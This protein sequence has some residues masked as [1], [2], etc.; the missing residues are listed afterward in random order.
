MAP[1]WF[2][3]HPP[4]GLK[5]RRAAGMAGLA[6]M[7]AVL[8]WFLV[9]SSS[10][11]EAIVVAQGP[12]ARKI[13]GERA[14]APHAPVRGTRPLWTE[15]TAAQ[16]QALAPLAANW[17]HLSETQKRKWLVLSKNYAR[18]SPPEQVRLHGRMDDWVALT[19]Q[20]RHTARFNFAETKRMTQDEKQEK[21]K[22]YQALSPD[23]RS[24]FID[25]AA[26][27]PQGAAA[28]VKPVPRQKLA[29]I[30]TEPNRLTRPRIARPGQINPRTLLPRQDASQAPIPRQNSP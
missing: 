2:P 12:V 3:M 22:A 26:P 8:P 27:Q 20:Q 29:N 11:A 19:A 6:T 4:H 28:A 1:S 16:H 9:A 14:S 13:P 30:E 21:W 15:L 17:D 23:D 10:Q 5:M 25:R 7:F 18:M 24:K